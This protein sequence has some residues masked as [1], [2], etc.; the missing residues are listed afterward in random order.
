MDNVVVIMDCP[1]SLSKFTFTE[2]VEIFKQK[3]SAKSTFNYQHDSSIF[4]K[5][6]ATLTKCSKSK[7]QER[8]YL[9]LLWN[10]KIKVS[11]F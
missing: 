10:D 11:F 5:V 2:I 1:E 7:I 3:Y 9:H 4:G 6:A 8:E